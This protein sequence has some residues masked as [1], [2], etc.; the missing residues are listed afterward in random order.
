MTGSVALV[1][2]PPAGVTSLHAS[3]IGDAAWL[4]L[5]LPLAGA[6]VLLLG[7]KRTNSFGHWIG[8]AM[9]VLAFGYAVAAFVQML[10][11]P[12]AQ[13]ARDLVVY[14]FINVGRFQI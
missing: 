1:T 11:Y 7:G 4:L 3:G 8:V 14:Q 12:A 10:G 2:L 6:A 5:A 9:P 13:R